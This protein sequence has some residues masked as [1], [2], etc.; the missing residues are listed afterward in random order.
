LSCAAESPRHLDGVF[1][2]APRRQ[3]GGVHARP[4]R[5]ALEQFHHGVRPFALR[6]EIMDGEDVGMRQCSDRPRFALE[7]GKPIRIV[8][9]Q[10]GKDFDRDVAIELRI[11]RAVDLAHAPCADDL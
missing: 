6:P 8:S 3:G 1:D 4:Q 10:V 7:S 9:E 5:H 2:G 11:A